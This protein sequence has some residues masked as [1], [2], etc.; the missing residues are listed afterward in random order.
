MKEITI[1]RPFARS[2][3]LRRGHAVFVISRL[4]RTGSRERK[5]TLEHELTGAN[6]I[7]KVAA[8]SAEAAPAVR[9]VG[10]TPIIGGISTRRAVHRCPIADVFGAKPD[11]G[12]RTSIDQPQQKERQGLFN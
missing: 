10:T 2:Q 7:P 6:D 8:A 3:H 5:A 4:A 12:R 1:W 9:K 11:I